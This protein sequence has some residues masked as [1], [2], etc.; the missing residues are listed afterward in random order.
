MLAAADAVTQSCRE[1]VSLETWLSTIRFLAKR[2][3]AYLSAVAVAYLL[4]SVTAT[5]A[6][7]ASLGGMGVEVGMADRLAMSLRDIPGMAPM[8]LPMIAFALLIAFMT[9]ALLSRWLRRWRLPLYLLAGATGLICIHV[10]LHLAF[11]IT[12]VA[13]ARTGAGLLVQGIAGALGGL[14][15]LALIKRTEAGGAKQAPGGSSE[16]AVQ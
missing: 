6:V 4:A 7:I 16:P 14:V 11:G 2:L 12:P 15:Y 8:F 13:I 10:G 3:A 5:Q 1:E 9:V